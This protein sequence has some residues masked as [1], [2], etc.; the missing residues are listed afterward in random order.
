[1]KFL[2]G[3]I[4]PRS[5][6]SG[7]PEDRET[8]QIVTE[9]VLASA[10]ALRLEVSTGLCVRISQDVTWDQVRRQALFCTGEGGL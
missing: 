7:H 3:K 9:R 6:S 5:F 8:Y 4:Q 1:M 10:L 2:L